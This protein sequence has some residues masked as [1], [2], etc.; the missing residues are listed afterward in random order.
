MNVWNKYVWTSH[1][2]VQIEHD[3]FS[4]YIKSIR[5]TFSYSLS[6]E[7]VR[8]SY[9]NSRLIRIINLENSCFSKDPKVVRIAPNLVCSIPCVNRK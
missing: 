9:G 5:G 1:R 4:V 6:L 8:F 7:G 3:V 2:V